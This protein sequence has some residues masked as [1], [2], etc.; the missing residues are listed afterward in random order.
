MKL[1]PKTLSWSYN[2]SKGLTT[3]NQNTKKKSR[4]AELFAFNNYHAK[5]S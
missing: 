5:N 3:Q 4:I 1:A 2:P